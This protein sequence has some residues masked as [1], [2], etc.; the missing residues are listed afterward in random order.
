[1]SALGG[2][3]HLGDHVGAGRLRRDLG[4][5]SSVEP[6]DEQRRGLLGEV[7][8]DGE[9]LAGQFGPRR[10]RRVARGDRPP[11]RH[12]HPSRRPRCAGRWPRPR[13]ATTATART[14]P[15]AGSRSG[16]PSVVG[17]EAAVF[18]PSGTMGN[19]IALRL[20]GRPGTAVA[21]GRRQHPVIYEAGAAGGQRV[22]RSCTCSTTTTA[23]STR[24]TLIELA[25]AA[26]AP[27]A[28]GER[29]V[30]R[31]HAHAGGR[32]AVAARA[33]R[34]GRG[35]RACRCTSTAPGCSTRR[36]RPARPPPPTRRHA[37]TVMC[38]LS[39]GLGAP[40][41]SMLAGSADADRRGAGRAQAARRLDAPGGRHRRRR[42]RRA[43]A[44]RPAGRRPPPSPL[45]RG[46]GRRA[47]A[48][49]RPRPR[50]GADELRAVPPRRH[51]SARSRTSRTKACRRE[52]SR[53]AS[54]GS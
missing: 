25:E 12:G 29:G 42:A 1:M 13:W 34:R 50:V 33:G 30:H 15:C 10:H 8:G 52:P 31:E 28:P 35:G 27:L 21:I 38:C 54:C 18:V 24:P 49:R 39:K 40:V 37:T 47:V 9:Q 2:A 5:T 45:A 11:L 19:Q 51:A 48:G 20:L 17:K 46:G 3:V 16:S 4:A 14:R 26:T 41:G 44:S 23:R 32:R 22:A 53:R 43:R 7:A 6:V 36:S